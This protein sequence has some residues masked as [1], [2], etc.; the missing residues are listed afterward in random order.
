MLDPRNL[1]SAEI[2]ELLNVYNEYVKRGWMNPNRH[3]KSG[4]L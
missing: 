3:L 1:S 4:Q 2:Q